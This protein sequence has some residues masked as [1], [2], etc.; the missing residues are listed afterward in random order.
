MSKYDTLR[1]KPTRCWINAISTHNPLHKHHGKVGIAF[2]QTNSL[3]FEHTTLYFS[4]GAVSS[5]E[6]DPLYLEINNSHAD[7]FKINEKK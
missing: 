6:V 3:G 5:M 1:K 2:T 7:I 4:E